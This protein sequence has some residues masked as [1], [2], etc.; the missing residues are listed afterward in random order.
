M[1]KLKHC[2]Y[3]PCTIATL[4]GNFVEVV[5]MVPGGPHFIYFI[6]SKPDEKARLLHNTRV[7]MLAK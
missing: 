3:G 5:N 6:T 4:Q 2:E 7:E 1:K